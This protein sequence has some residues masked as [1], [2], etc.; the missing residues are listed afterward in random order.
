MRAVF[1][2][3]AAAFAGLGQGQAETLPCPSTC[4]RAM[5]YCV[6]LRV[7]DKSNFNCE[8][9]L[10]SCQATGWWHGPHANCKMPKN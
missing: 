10:K 4:E 6:E 7:R 2:V 9:Q 5:Q 1:L 8:G 3:V